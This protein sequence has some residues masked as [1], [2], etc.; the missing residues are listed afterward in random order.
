V[1]ETKSQQFISCNLQTRISE[2]CKQ[3]I[4]FVFTFPYKRRFILRVGGGG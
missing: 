2:Q 1:E 3:I 4:Y